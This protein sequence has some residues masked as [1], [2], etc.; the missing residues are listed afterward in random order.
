MTIELK[1]LRKLI[2]TLE[3][4]IKE[5]DKSEEHEDAVSNIYSVLF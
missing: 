2:W 3:K 1:N 5:F 4:S